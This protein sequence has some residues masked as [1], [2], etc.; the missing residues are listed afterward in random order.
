MTFYTFTCI[1]NNCLGDPSQIANESDSVA[2]LEESEV[3]VTWNDTSVRA[4]S[5]RLPPLFKEYQEFLEFQRI[6]ASQV[7]AQVKTSSASSL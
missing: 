7:P 2:D 4:S 3:E 5:P 6:R 1:V